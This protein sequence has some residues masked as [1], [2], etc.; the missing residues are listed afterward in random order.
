MPRLNDARS[1]ILEVS[2]NLAQN[3]GFSGF[4]FRDIADE[5]GIKS[6]SIHY[7]FPTKDDLIIELARNYRVDFFGA[8]EAATQDI[9][10]P[11]EKITVL[12]G[13]FRHVLVEENR[14]CL[15][16]MLAADA[17]LLSQEAR[18]EIKHFYEAS[19]EWLSNEWEKLGYENSRERAID[20]FIRLE[21]ALLISRIAGSHEPFDV[22]KTEIEKAIKSAGD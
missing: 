7:H 11:A 21:G 22:A 17:R 5:I 6:A 13:M 20:T 15:C 10:S 3:W 14:M 16:G 19:I 2:Q 18:D 4:S 1:K 9:S 8:L 12:I